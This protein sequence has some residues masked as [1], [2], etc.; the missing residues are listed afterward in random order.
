M[1]LKVRTTTEEHSTWTAKA[2]SAG[3]TL[4]DLVRHA[5]DGTRMRRRDRAAVDPALLRQLA[6]IGNNLNQ[7]ARWANRDRSRVE[8]AA[9]IAHLIEIDRELAVIRSRFEQ[10]ANAD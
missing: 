1:W 7:L 9:V 4:S 3:L 10:A 2:H 6:H 5:L 8:A